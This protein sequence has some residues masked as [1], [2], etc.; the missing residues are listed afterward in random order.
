MG[1][2]LPPVIRVRIGQWR[3]A[4]HIRQIAAVVAGDLGKT[5]IEMDDIEVPVPDGNA[6]RQMM[7]EV[8]EKIMLGLHFLLGLGFMA[9]G[10]TL[11]DKQID[12]QTDQQQCQDE[13]GV[14]T[15]L[16][17]LQA[18]SLIVEDDLGSR[19]ESC[20]ILL[21]FCKVSVIRDSIMARVI[22]ESAS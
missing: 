22:A 4:A 7:Q 21:A 10:G 11:T 1:V 17:G 3:P 18:F 16:E 12:Q 13:Q 8:F 20:L 6:E 19:S 2:D 14:D 5:G 9:D 15:L